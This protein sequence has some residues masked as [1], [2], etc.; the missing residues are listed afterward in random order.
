MRSTGRSV[1]RRDCQP[2]CLAPRV[3]DKRLSVGPL[4][5]NRE[6]K[7]HDKCSTSCIAAISGRRNRCEYFDCSNAL[8]EDPLKIV[9]GKLVI[10]G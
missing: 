5:V 4:G 2:H 3:G 8:L 9:E 7:D 6:H 1:V 10:P